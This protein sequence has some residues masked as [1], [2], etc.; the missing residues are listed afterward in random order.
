MVY[1]KHQ[2]GPKGPESPQNGPARVKEETKSGLESIDME[3]ISVQGDGRIVQGN[4]TFDTSN[5]Q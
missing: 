5:M 2:N 4:L 1:R 3:V